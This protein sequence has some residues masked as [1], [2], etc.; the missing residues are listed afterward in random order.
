MPV[1][2]KPY[3]FSWVRGTNSPF[4]VRILAPGDP[5][6]SDPLPF[7]DMRLSV[8]AGSNL[9]FRLST[10][11]TPTQALV[12]NTTKQV[13]FIPTPEQTR[14]LIQTKDG[15]LPKYEVEL[16]NGESEEVYLMGNITGIGGINDDE[17]ED[18]S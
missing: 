10:L 13:S 1:V 12:N 9:A 14:M 8:F 4:Q 11:D 2:P 15:A 17:T 5:E 3:D 16:R 6:T 7:D 18:A